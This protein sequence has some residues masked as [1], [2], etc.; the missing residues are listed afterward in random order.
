MAGTGVEQFND[1]VGLDLLSVIL[2]G[3][4]SAWLVQELREKRQWVLDINSGFSLQ[5]D[6]S[7]F[8]IQAWLDAEHL[9]DVEQVIGDRLAD[10]QTCCV[11]EEE[12][13][14]AKRMLC[15]EHIFSTES[16]SQLAGLYGYYQ[17][18]GSLD[19]AHHYPRWWK[20]SRLSR[21]SV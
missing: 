13:R 12:L 9:D 15:N 18:L 8:T 14:R 10:L 11:S 19:Y 4:T 5:R 2:A 17:T 6:S 7:L 16:A 21:S 1:A 20:P 3:T